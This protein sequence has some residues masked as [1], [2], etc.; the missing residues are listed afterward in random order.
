MDS[1][2][3][4]A[5]NPEADVDEVVAIYLKAVQMG[6]P[7][8]PEEFIARHPA[9]AK[10]LA[11]FFAGQQYLQRLAEPVR[12]ALTGVPSLGKVIR[13]FGDYELLEEIGR[14]GMGVV[15]RARQVSLHR[16]VAL[17]LILAGQFASP[18]DVQ[19]FH[20]EAE[21]AAHLDHPH[22][23]PIYEVGE[24]D[25]HHYF[26]MKLVEGASLASGRLPL[27]ARKAAALLATVS[28]A[29]HYA[30]QRGILHRD[31]KPGNVL[32]D[33]QGQ[34]YVTDFGLAKRLEG[35]VPHTR[36]GGILGTPSYM[37]PEQARS[38]K[39]LTTGVDVYSLGAILYEMLTGRPPFR[40]DTPLDTILQVLDREP[41][42]PHNLDPCVD[43]DLETICLKC[44][45]KEPEK[46][47]G[48]AEALAEE[49]DRW[50]KGEPILARPAGR[51]ERMWRWCRRNQRVAASLAGLV[52]T[53]VGGIVVAWFLAVA[54]SNNAER[55]DREAAIARE[56]AKQ[57]R[58][59]KRLSEHRYYASE[60][61]LASLELEGRQLS[62]LRQRL[63]QFASKPASQD[64]RGFEWYYLQ[65]Q[66]QLAFRSIA[67]LGGTPRSVAYGPDG[68]LLASISPN[69]TVKVW[70]T[71]TDQEHFAFR[72][73][74][75]GANAVTWCPN[76]RLLASAGEDRTVKVWDLA[77]GQ[78]T[79]TLRGHTAA[80]WC[81]AFSSDGRLLASAG[82]AQSVKVWSVA[83]WRETLTLSA[84]TNQVWCVAF[85]PDSRHLASAGEKGTVQVWDVNTGHETLT[86][87]GHTAAVRSVAFSPDGRR[88][89]SASKDRTVK[90]WDTATGHETLTFRLHTDYVSGVA[91]SPDGRYI[92]SASKDWTVKIW[93]TAT[94][95]EVF[96]LN[97]QR[98]AVWC[99]AFSP[100]GQRIASADDHGIAVRN[101][102]T[103]H[104]TFTFRGHRDAVSDVAFSPDGRRIASA[105][106]DQTLRIWDVNTGQATLTLRGH[107]DG[108]TAVAFSSDGRHIASGSRDQTVKIWDI[109][110]GQET[111][112]LRG[113]PNWVCGMAFS[114]AGRRLASVSVDGTVKIWDATTGQGIS[115]FQ[116]H[117]TAREGLRVAFSADGRMIA[118]ISADAV[119]FF[120]ATTGQETRTWPGFGW[121][122]HGVA[123]SPES[124]RLASAGQDW[125]VKLWDAVT[126]QETLTLRGHTAPVECMTFSSDGRRLASAGSD[127]TVKVWDAATGQE[128]LSLRGHTDAI[129]A[130]A[131]S[132]DGRRFVC[133]SNDGMVKVWDAAPMTEEIWLQRQATSI[134][135][136]LISRSL[137]K[138]QVMAAIRQ[139]RTLGVAL[140][141]A[142]LAWVDQGFELRATQEAER[143][144]TSLFKQLLLRSDVLKRI[145]EDQSLAKPAQQK[146]LILARQWPEDAGA[147]RLASW[148]VVRQPGALLERY[149]Q[150]LRY[151][152]AACSL[153]P[154]YGDYLNTLGVAQY[155]CGRYREALTTLTHSDQINSAGMQHSQ[156]F[157][158]AFLAM[159]QFQLGK[160]AEA[161]SMLARLIEIMK[162][163]A[164]VWDE[165]QSGRF[166]REAEALIQEKKDAKPLAGRKP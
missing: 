99:V 87:R 46:R 15:Y 165:A 17:K 56:S 51:T 124:R 109:T 52:A 48:S 23:V 53:L 73:H 127:Q 1:K 77:T 132:P 44:L 37:P 86:L 24:Q 47:Y 102:V 59:E 92:A 81:V 55:A 118:S 38:E 35:T 166:L 18:E 136:F 5:F 39:V 120:D 149:A 63:E 152:E 141:Q 34:P 129:N 105:S 154:E 27:P 100:D 6:A 8:S 67:E 49:L 116:G 79:L 153:K 12:Q 62:L 60:M 69:G 32:L 11:E 134:V 84:D 43:R 144:V 78:E 157:D 131:F 125:T 45:Q 61:K 122:G 54:A 98:G 33:A 4:L 151:A 2:E 137:S 20:R 142:A 64:L 117:L 40:A 140:R 101:A 155:R 25:G 89:A 58:E 28:H 14:G 10:E 113:H 163:G 75:G 16:I 70:D 71:A 148:E 7:P 114:S 126:G 123:F 108:V 162:P 57:A 76:G 107:K 68:R 121:H 119:K 83:A 3:T 50:L 164:V 139:D 112:T 88:L 106:G 94:G 42:V 30:H 90:I 85:S 104:E 26:S 159:T 143:V 93:D 128:I 19:R 160:M 41:E 158:L 130:V 95:Q 65:R 135:Q 29:M 138:D 96:T 146:A 13:Y 103:S 36:T 31:L 74:K 97:E 110:T 21:A 133:G 91:F 145:Q 156:P 22:I 82:S 9:L 80:V 66:S 150:A 115:T 72:G 147:L 161:R 111:R